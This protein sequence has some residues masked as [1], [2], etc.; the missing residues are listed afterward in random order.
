MI[1]GNQNMRYGELLARHAW[2]N[3]RIEQVDFSAVKWEQL[4][5]VTY[6]YSQG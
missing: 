3:V 6:L 2:G 1:I 4:A 5:I